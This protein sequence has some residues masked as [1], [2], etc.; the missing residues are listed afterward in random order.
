MKPNSNLKLNITVKDL[1]YIV[2][3]ELNGFGVTVT[4]PAA[5]LDRVAHIEDCYAAESDS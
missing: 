3:H 5:M 1:I 4:D 2:E